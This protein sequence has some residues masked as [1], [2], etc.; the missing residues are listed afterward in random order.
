VLVSCATGPTVPSDNAP[1]DI[2]SI[3]EIEVKT[4]G[5][6]IACFPVHQPISGWVLYTTETGDLRPVSRVEFIVVSGS[7]RGRH[8]DIQVDSEGHFAGEVL[9]WDH[10][11]GSAA[12]SNDTEFIPGRTLVALQASG[13]DEATLDIG[14]DWEPL[15]VTMKC[16]GRH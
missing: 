3:G 5:A 13:C 14:H 9:L 16:P 8:L 7:G 1:I 6:R 4:R 2:S 15:T 10:E 12:E 11:V